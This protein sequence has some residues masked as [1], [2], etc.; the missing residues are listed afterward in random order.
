MRPLSPKT[1]GLVVAALVVLALL[2]YGFWPDPVAVQTAEVSRGDLQVTVEEEGTTAVQDRYVVTAPVAGTLQRLSLQAGDAVAAGDTLAVLR[3]PAAPVLDG[4]GRAEAE[5]RLTGAEAGVASA[6]RQADAADA[7][8]NRA[9]AER[10][11]VERLHE[12]GSATQRQRQQAVAEA[13][14]AE[15]QAAAAQAGIATARADVRAARATLAGGMDEEPVASVVRAPAAGQVLAVH[16][17]SEGPVQPGEPLVE[18][19]N[20]AALKVQVDVLSQDALRIRPGTPVLLEQWGGPDTLRATVERV[21]PDGHTDISAL[22]VEEQRVTVHARLDTRPRDDLRLG[23]GFRVLA[24]FIVWE[25][26]DVLQVPTSAL[27]RTSD[28]WAVFVVA[29]GR[30][31]RRPVELGERSGLRAEVRAGLEEG[32]TVIAHPSNEMEDGVRVRARD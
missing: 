12:Q 16:R 20:T 30:T 9:R 4:R 24:R 26:R 19:G 17:E 27:F 28:G 31:E 3:A 29:G 15:A 22:G 7:V 1:I 8:A 10:R 2:V 32:E 21:D 6:E 5:A 18:V 13:L 23:S 25:G 14:Q 11:R